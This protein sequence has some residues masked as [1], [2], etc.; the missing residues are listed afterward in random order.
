MTRTYQNS[1]WE[2][3]G[4][5]ADTSGFM[6]LDIMEVFLYK[7]HDSVVTRVHFSTVDRKSNNTE[8]AR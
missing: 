7:T 5:E 4:I 3:G 1:E 2:Y 8:R 6:F